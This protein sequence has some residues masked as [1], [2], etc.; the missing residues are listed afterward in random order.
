MKYRL[1]PA[2]ERDID[3]AASWYG[4]HAL[5]PGVPERFLRELR[6]TFDAF[7]EAPLAFPVVHR[8][9]RRR[10]LRAF[11]T[12]AVFYRVIGDVVVVTAIF[13]GRRRPHGWQARR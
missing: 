5:D 9:I 6:A 10:P 11:P 13:H 8:D 7:V 12:Y 2:A 4:A 3:E 1:R